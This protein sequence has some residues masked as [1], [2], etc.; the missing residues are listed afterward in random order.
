MSPQ[1]A[2]LVADFTP[3]FKVA[4][5]EIT[6]TGLIR[7]LAA[8][9]KPVIIS[10]GNASLDE[11]RTAV[12]AFLTV[13]PDAA[14][15]GSLMLMHCVAA[16]PVPPDQAN[17]RNI[18]TLQREFGLA[19]GYSDH[20]LGIKACELAVA[21]G[22]VALEKHFTYRKEDQPFRD[23]QLSADPEDLKN[24]VGAV[25]Q[26]ETY[27]GG[28]ERVRQACETEILDGMRR[29]VAAAADIPEGAQLTSSMLTGL[30]PLWGIPVEQTDDVI[31]K[32]TKR[33]IA[34]GDLIAPEDL[35][36]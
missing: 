36:D 22:A 11:I 13:R 16:Y 7:H 20:T 6:W 15:D 24:L 34:Q 26:A 3:I 4:S 19:V 9:G 10:T 21:A 8:S 14:G 23:H 27:L 25:R 1:D 35:Q 17:L 31:G 30:R 2:D 29:S 33:A 32:T 12:D 5:G 18:G 28:T